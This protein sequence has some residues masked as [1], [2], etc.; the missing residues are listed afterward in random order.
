MKKIVVS[1]S[2]VLA[3]L[4]P[5]L[6]IAKQGT[7]SDLYPKSFFRS[8]TGKA[9]IIA[10]SVVVVGAITY[11]T[12][13][14]GTAAA[15]GPIATWVGTKI[16]VM[17]GYSGIAA[18]NVGLATLGGG[19]VASGGFG[20]LGGITV[21]SAL[22]DLTLALA[23]ERAVDQFDKPYKKYE[24]IKL[25]LPKKGDPRILDII[26]EID[27]TVENFNK[28]DVNPKFLTMTIDKYYHDILMLTNSIVRDDRNAGYSHLVRGVVKY[29]LMDYAG[30]KKEIL[31]AQKFFPESSFA[32]YVLALV[33]LVDG[34][35]T[36]SISHA[37]KSISHEKN[38]A[39]SYILLTQIYMDQDRNLR[40]ID[41]AT[42]GLKSAA[43]E[44]HEKFTLNLMLGNIYYYNIKNYSKAIDHYK[45]AIKEMRVKEYK[46][47][48]IVMVAKSYRSLKDSKNAEKWLDNALKQVRKND[49]YVAMLRNSYRDAY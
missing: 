46:A 14:T 8:T 49:D 27:K 31:A 13:G 33:Y 44:S 18:T 17:A 21:I 7:F 3:S 29:N 10:G 9:T 39:E 38:A 34:N 26:S 2:I 37:E 48:C 12:A 20:I 42:S 28:G 30:A 22:G 41:V 35:Y 47:E 24:L 25:D 11:F 40:A 16:G 43:K 19:S 4:M 32:E 6:A 15:A 1:L 5:T 36:K 45:A 23:L